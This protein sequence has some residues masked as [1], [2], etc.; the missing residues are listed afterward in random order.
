[1]AYKSYILMKMQI[2]LIEESSLKKTSSRK[3]DA[4][5]YCIVLKNALKVHKYRIFIILRV[6]DLLQEKHAKEEEERKRRIQ[7]YVFVLRCVAY[8]FNAKQPN[9]MQKRHLKVT[10]EGH[11]KMKAKIEVKAAFIGKILS[12][13]SN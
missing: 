6:F 7:L 11:E 8:N 4:K 5:L 10:K 3:D 13:F 9:D 2:R 1:M 12:L